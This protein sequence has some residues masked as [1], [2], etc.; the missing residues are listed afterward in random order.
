MNKLEKKL[1]QLI[2]DFRNEDD[3]SKRESINRMKADVYEQLKPSTKEKIIYF[4]EKDLKDIEQ[5]YYD[6]VEDIKADIY[7]AK[8]SLLEYDKLQR[9]PIPYCIVKHKDKYFFTIRENG[10]GEIRLIGK[11]GLLGGHVGEKDISYKNNKIDFITTMRNGMLREIAEEAGITQKI[12]ESI[13]FKGFL[14]LFDGV[15][16]DHLGMIYEIELKNSNIDAI[17]KGV[18]EGIWI[19]KTEII[20][21]E[22]KLEHW[23]W[24]AWQNI[25]N[26]S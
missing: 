7:T 16:E 17:E 13:K 6:G 2:E 10:S 15:E 24:L 12:I 20:N 19:N 3:L 23:A 4:L 11:V 21:M 18:L 22:D 1:E 8:R 5:G 9:H 14:K 26:K 25:I